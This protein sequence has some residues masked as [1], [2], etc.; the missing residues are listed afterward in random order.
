[1]DMLLINQTVKRL[2]L[3]FVGMLS[4]QM[5]CQS[6]PAESEVH[7]KMMSD[8]VAMEKVH[9]TM[10]EEHKQMEGDHAQMKTDHEKMLA[11]HKGEGE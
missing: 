2:A 10:E 7:K 9:T 8:H 1:M 4:L 6:N 5:G 11:D 3:E